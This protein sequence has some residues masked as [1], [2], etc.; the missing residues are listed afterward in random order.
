MGLCGGEEG[1]VF[2]VGFAD[3]A[4]YPVAVDGV[5]EGSF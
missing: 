2:A 3:E 4:F 5:S 1:F